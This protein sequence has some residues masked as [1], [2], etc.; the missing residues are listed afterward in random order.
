[1]NLHSIDRLED[2]YFKNGG[3]YIKL[4]Q[5]IGQLVC[6]LRVSKL[7]QNFNVL[8][9]HGVTRRSCYPLWGVDEKI[10]EDV[11]VKMVTTLLL[12]KIFQCVCHYYHYLSKVHPFV[13][14]F[15]YFSS[16]RI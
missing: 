7:W 4:G 12:L 8:L 13:N 2:I 1:M 14:N 3:I 9:V 15:D 6:L 10:N 16:E 5:H 11:M